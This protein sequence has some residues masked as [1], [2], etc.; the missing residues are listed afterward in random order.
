MAKLMHDNKII[1]SLDLEELENLLQPHQKSM[2]D[3]LGFSILNRVVLEHNLLLNSKLHDDITF[4]ELGTLLGIPAAKV[5]KIVC[6]MIKEKRLKGHVN[7]KRSIVYFEG[8][9]FQ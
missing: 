2:S 1:K 6:R 5:N 7:Q 4:D 9:F 3:D 8:K